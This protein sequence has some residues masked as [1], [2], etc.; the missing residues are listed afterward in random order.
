MNKYSLKDF[1][2]DCIEATS[3]KLTPADYTEKLTPALYQLLNGSLDFLTPDHFRSHPEHYER[4]LIYKGED[5]SLSIYSLVWLPGQMT[6]IHDHG[7]WGLVGVVEGALQERNFIRIDQQ[8][9]DIDSNIEL[10][11]GGVTILAPGAVTSFVPNPDHIHI[12][13]NP[14]ADKRVVSIHLY[15]CNMSGY[16]IYDLESKSRS[17]VDVDCNR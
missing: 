12:A 10:V 4:N 8:P 11:R 16:N 3:Q 2:N 9:Q 6:P 7:T 1:I 13:G 5:N 15:G 17:Y 14:A